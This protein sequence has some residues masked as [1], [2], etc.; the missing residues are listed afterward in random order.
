MK[1]PSPYRN[2]AR[3]SGLPAA[4]LV[5]AGCDAVNDAIDAADDIG[6]DADVF[7]YVSL[8]TSLSVGVQPTSGGTLLPTTDGYPDQLF[9]LIKADFE[10]AAPNREL[11]LRKLGCPGETLDD[12]LNGGSCAYVAGSQLDAGIDF[13][14]DNAEKVLLTGRKIDQKVY[15]KYTGW[16]GGRRE[17]SVREMLEKK[18][19][20]VV[21]LAVR[22]MLPKTKLGRHMLK[23]LKIYAGNEHPH[24]AQD[25]QP[26]EIGEFI[27]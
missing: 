27:G 10:A 8:G 25:P 2:W 5:V 13:L 26:L 14:S 15:V 18:P 9:D 21:R 7:Y 3:L 12:M 17:T 20:E 4:V 6:N 16:A 24:E 22:R 1:A 19:E 23:K 11:R